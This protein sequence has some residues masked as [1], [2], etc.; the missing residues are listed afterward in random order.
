[1]DGHH[2]SFWLQVAI[3]C[4]NER[5]ATAPWRERSFFLTRTIS[6]ANKNR[7]IAFRGELQALNSGIDANINRRSHRKRIDKVLGCVSARSHGSPAFNNVNH[8]C[9]ASKRG[10]T[11][12]NR[13]GIPSR[14]GVW[15]KPNSHREQ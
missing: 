14:C 5:Q 13:V 7:E 2:L 9:V 12:R 11:E 3:R 1:L 10:Q 6:E 8:D 15:V 4:P